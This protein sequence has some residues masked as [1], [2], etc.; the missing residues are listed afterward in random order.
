MFF[1][2][3]LPFPTR[4]LF[5]VITCNLVQFSSTMFSNFCWTSLVHQWQLVRQLL[6][7]S[8]RF[9]QSLF[10]ILDIFPFSLVLFPALLYE[11][12]T[13]YL[14]HNMIFLSYQE[15]LHQVYYAQF[16]GQFE[17]GSPITNTFTWSFSITPSGSWSYHLSLH[18]MLN[19]WQSFQWITW[20][21]LSCRHI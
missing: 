8:S 18:G 20:P 7:G 5:V 14:S 13:R 16:D 15:Q 10:L 6:F 12:G 3:F 19:F 17:F 11:K 4:R 21:T 1:S 9:S 2:R